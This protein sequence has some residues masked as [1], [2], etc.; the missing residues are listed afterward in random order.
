MSVGPLSQLRSM[1]RLAARGLRARGAAP[2]WELSVPRRRVALERSGIHV[3]AARLDAYGRATDGDG[4]VA[5][6]GPHAVAPPFYPATWEVGLALEMLAALDTPLPLGPMV[7]LSSD[8]VWARPVHAGDAVRCRVEL[9]RVERAR[10]GLRITVLAR[11]WLPGGQLCCQSS[12]VF[13]LRLRPRDEHGERGDGPPAE[14]REPRAPEEG[15]TELARWAL[16]RG[17]GRRYAR[18]SGDYNPIH[19]WSLTARPVGFRAPILHGFATAARAAHGIIHQRLGGDGCALRRMR[20]AFRA[21]LPLPSAPVLQVT[22][23]GGDRWFRVAG[24]DGTTVHAEGTYG[25]AVPV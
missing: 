2:G 9:D 6:R 24:E 10:R 16:P 8:V 19:L 18:V 22:D 20:I 11:N 3:D 1:L 5:F 15:W 7:H 13:L 4:I 17:A 14:S 23:A 21:P 12:S 25:A